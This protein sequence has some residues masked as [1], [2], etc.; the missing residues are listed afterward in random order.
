MAISGKVF[1]G[2][3]SLS[4]YDP[5]T[6]TTVQLNRLALESTAW[7]EENITN[8][9]TQSRVFGGRR[10]SLVLGFFDSDGYAQLRT[11]Q[12]NFT[13]VR[14]V[15][16]SHGQNLQWYEDT[17]I[18]VTKSIKADKRSGLNL[19]LLEAE[20]IGE[21]PEIYTN[22]NL[23]A[24]LGDVDSATIIF[25]IASTTLTQSTD[26]SGPGSMSLNAKNF[27][28][29]SLASNSFTYAG[30]GIELINLALPSATYQIDVA[31]TSAT[32]EF[33]A[34]TSNGQVTSGTSF[35]DF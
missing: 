14:M 11:W 6:G 4:V 24:Y 19:Y 1:S 3:K 18:T 16:N 15:A 5:A 21:D 17:T 9:T 7:T 27:A 25:P 2:W 26:V 28:G 8:E 13:P 35:M 33:N 23:L 12:E 22:Q 20:F 29:S 10:Y 34:V 31:Y 30:N 32:S